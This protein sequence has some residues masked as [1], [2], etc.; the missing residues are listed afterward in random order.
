MSITIN[1]ITA[2]ATAPGGE[3]YS[4]FYYSTYD[5]D[6]HY[7]YISLEN[8]GTMTFATSLGV[9]SSIVIHLDAE[10][11]SAYGYGEGWNYNANAL[12]WTGNAASVV[13]GNDG[14]QYGASIHHIT[15]IYFTVVSVPTSTSWNL[16]DL[17]SISISQYHGQG[18]PMSQTING[19]TA[20]A[21]ALGSDDNSEFFYDG[22]YGNIN[23]ENEGTFTFSSPFGNLASIVIH[24]TNEFGIYTNGWS[25]DNS[26]HTL[27]WTGNA[28][29]VVLGNDEG[30]ANIS[31]I[32]SIDLAVVSVAAPTSWDL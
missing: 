32:T 23:L 6:D 14:G 16:S 11:G 21:T 31:Y 4:G 7:S 8:S 10:K 13:L 22:S 3:D 20:T 24:T 12:S 19:I 15:S 26:E 30:Y 9:L 27:S 2:T 28:A 1:G 18:E 29:S 5:N 17:A 25:W